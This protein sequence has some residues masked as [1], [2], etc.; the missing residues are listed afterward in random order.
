[1]GVGL[2][3]GLSGGHV[4]KLIKF[5]HSLPETAVGKVLGQELRTDEPEASPQMDS[6]AG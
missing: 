1:V 6:T 5:R 4:P 3:P 2:T